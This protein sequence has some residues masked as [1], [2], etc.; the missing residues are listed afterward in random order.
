MYKNLIKEGQL[1]FA[2]KKVKKRDVDFSFDILNLDKII[3]FIWARRVW[4]TSFMIYLAKE[5]IKQKKLKL[6]QIVFI[7][8]SN[9][10]EEKFDPKILLEDFFELYPDLEPFFIFDE[11]QELWDFKKEILFLFNKKYKIFL[12][13]SNSKLLSSELSTQF[14]WRTYDLKIYPLSFKEFYRFKFDKN[15]DKKFSSQEKWE[16]KSI[17][18]EYLKFWAYP[19]ISL[20]DDENIK[21]NILKDYFEV[22]LYKDLLERYWISNEY[23]IKYLIKKI[24]LSNTKIFSVN[25]IFSDL[26]SQNVKIWV[27]TLYNYLE[28]LKQIFFIF[29][30]KNKYKLEKKYYLNDVWF[31]NLVDKNNFW[32]RFENIIFMHLLQKFWNIEYINDKSEID[33]VIEK[34]NLAIQVCYNL[35]SENFKREIKSLKKSEFEKK[36][37]VYFYKERNFSEEWVEILDVFEFFEKIFF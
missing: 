23:W 31:I 32:Q 24:F 20:I 8:F 25:K 5:L 26:K 3:S 30:I 36:Y 16:L 4:K 6:E 12:S 13:W 14:R 37:L 9:F 19:E 22:M 17:F 18:N 11:I 35:N 10:F 1:D 27:Q 7:D 33:F 21:N 2:S 34:E 28:Y 29:E 15:L